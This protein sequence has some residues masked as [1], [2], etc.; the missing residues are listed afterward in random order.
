[1]RR[2]MRSRWRE[3]EKEKELK[4]DQKRQ[5]Y[6]SS[7]QEEIILIQIEF[8]CSLKYLST[9]LEGEEEFVSLK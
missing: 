6:N 9:H 8:A 1:M 4:C 5:S 3:R 2:K 7:S